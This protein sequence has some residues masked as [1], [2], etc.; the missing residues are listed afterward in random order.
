M[1]RRL[2]REGEIAFDPFD[3]ANREKRPRRKRWEVEADRK[4]WNARID[5]AV[6]TAIGGAGSADYVLSWTT[7]DAAWTELGG[8]QI[9]R[10]NFEASM[11]RL[12]FVK[13]RNPGSTDGRWKLDGRWTFVYRR[14][15]LDDVDQKKLRKLFGC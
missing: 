14:T 11:K 4:A 2:Y 9:V 5:A 7:I 10:R 1:A 12:G 15:D 6:D 8:Q 3:P 13:M